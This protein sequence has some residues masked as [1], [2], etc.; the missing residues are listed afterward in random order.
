MQ[1]YRVN[2]E[3]P[4]QEVLDVIYWFQEISL[5]QAQRTMR[6]GY[7]MEKNGS[8]RNLRTGC[9]CSKALRRFLGRRET[10][11]DRRAAELLESLSGHKTRG[12]RR[13]PQVLR[14]RSSPPAG[15][16]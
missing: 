3:V 6:L 13:P 9:A 7:P 12:G 5:D 14:I 2:E 8:L 1:K 11:L 4:W 15:R 10:K 16:R